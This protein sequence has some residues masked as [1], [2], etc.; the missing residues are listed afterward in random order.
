MEVCVS[1][2]RKVFVVR[3]KRFNFRENI[4]AS[5]R[6]IRMLGGGGGGGR[7]HYTHA[8]RN[9]YSKLHITPFGQGTGCEHME[10]VSLQA[11]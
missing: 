9:S 4:S 2:H 6:D 5:C 1:E 8:V 7:L 10:K 3:N 11:L